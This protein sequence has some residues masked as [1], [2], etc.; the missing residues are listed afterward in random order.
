MDL[1]DIYRRFHST[2]TEYTFFSPANGNF[3]KIGLIL[4]HKKSQQIKEN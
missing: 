2:V 3:S 1:I 4:G